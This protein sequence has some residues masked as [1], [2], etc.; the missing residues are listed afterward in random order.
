MAKILNL[1]KFIYIYSKDK[2][3]EMKLSISTKAAKKETSF[4]N[5]C[6]TLKKNKRFD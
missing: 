3:S 2:G 1:Y 6:G 5:I 4:F